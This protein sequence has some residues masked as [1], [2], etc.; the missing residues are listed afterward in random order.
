MSS[1]DVRAAEWVK[2]LTLAFL[3]LSDARRWD[4]PFLGKYISRNYTHL[5]SD[6]DVLPE[7]ADDGPNLLAELCQHL[8]CVEEKKPDYVTKILDC[9]VTV[10]RQKGEAVAWVLTRQ[11]GM[12]VTTSSIGQ[13]LL[14]KYKWLQRDG[15]WKC[16]G[17]VGIRGPGGWASPDLVP[18]DTAH[19]LQADSDGSLLRMNEHNFNDGEVAET[20]LVAGERRR[21]LAQPILVHLAYDHPSVRLLETRPKQPRLDTSS[22]VRIMATCIACH[23]PLS[24]QLT[25]S[26]LRANGIKSRRS[27]PKLR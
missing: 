27:K 26:L 6:V 18:I 24:T 13:E 3:T 25:C 12:F 22:S 11:W 14:I 21:A 20:R 2:W 9:Q 19:F 5:G 17:Y 16:Y 1:T 7:V 10:E 23:P 4:S 15:R 8:R